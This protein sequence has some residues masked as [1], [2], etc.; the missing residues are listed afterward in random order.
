MGQWVNRV[1]GWT[2]H[3]GLYSYKTAAVMLFPFNCSCPLSPDP[4]SHPSPESL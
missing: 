2:L 1:L 3:L 4:V